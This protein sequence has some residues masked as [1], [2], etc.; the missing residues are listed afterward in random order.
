MQLAVGKH[1]VRLLNIDG[2]KNETLTVT[3][4]ERKPTTIDRK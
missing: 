3:I 2:D 1:K 4:D